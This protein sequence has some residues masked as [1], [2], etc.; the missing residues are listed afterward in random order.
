METNLDLA[1]SVGMLSVVFVVAVGYGVQR[2]RGREAR[3]ARVAADGG[4]VLLGQGT[5]SATYW[6]ME[7]PLRACEVMGATP[8]GVTWAS[9]VFALGAGVLL[10][11][12]HL[13]LGAFLA[14][15]SVLSDILDGQLARRLGRSSD[16]GELLDASVDRIGEFAFFGGL[17]VAFREQVWFMILSLLALQ[18]SS[19]V[20]YASA[21]A[22]ALR[23]EAPRG[24]MR[25][26]ERAAYLLTGT[27]FVPITEALAAH[28]GWSPAVKL[29]PLWGALGLIAVLAHYSAI[30][31]LLFV[32]RA[33][34]EFREVVP[35]E[36][37]KGEPHGA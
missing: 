8:N 32:A 33:L 7:L 29:V 25:R 19:L 10:G 4:S 14:I 30:T 16:R 13:G 21:K 24:L 28:L 15:L 23:V 37:P 6:L 34:P 35:S 11:L 3:F 20:S 9:L 12:G 17:A 22:E 36:A 5:M 31:R 18:G 27:S 26:S 1:A 2:L